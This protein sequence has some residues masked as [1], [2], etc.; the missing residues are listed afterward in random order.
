MHVKKCQYAANVVGW[1]D[2]DAPLL[3]SLAAWAVT[4][5]NA[6]DNSAVKGQL[7]PFPE[8]VVDFLTRLDQTRRDARQLNA[9]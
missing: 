4:V 6:I 3:R 8:G 9:N 2:E 1:D 5:A 7:I